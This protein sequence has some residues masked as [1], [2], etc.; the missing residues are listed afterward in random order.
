MEKKITRKDFLRKSCFQL[1]GFFEEI[2]SSELNKFEGLFPDRIRPPGALPEDEFILKCSRCKACVKACPF[3]VIKS[4]KEK[5]SLDFG[6]P[7]IDTDMGFC[8]MCEDFPCIKSCPTQSLNKV[9]A[10]SLK[11]GIAIV[12]RKSCV[13]IA[14]ISCMACETACPRKFDAVSF[15]SPFSEPTIDS[16]KCTGC[17]ACQNLCPAVPKAI[18]VVSPKIT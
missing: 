14:K 5:T 9:S 8:R 2:F 4:V 1:F 18:K 17:G 13:R 16:L 15:E 6:T 10:L 12:E 3:F 7:F 11:I